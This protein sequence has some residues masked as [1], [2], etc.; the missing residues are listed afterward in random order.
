M[1]PPF[2]VFPGRHFAQCDR[3]GELG[4]VSKTLGTVASLYHL[5]AEISRDHIHEG[6]VQRQ[7]KFYRQRRC[8][9]FEFEGISPPSIKIPSQKAVCNVENVVSQRVECFLQTSKMADG[10]HV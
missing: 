2:W 4:L 1:I 6:R 9:E 7:D 10:G 5:A 8:F 3:S